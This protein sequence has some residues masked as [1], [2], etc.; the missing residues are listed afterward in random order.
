[1]EEKYGRRGDV[2][3]QAPPKLLVAYLAG[4]I[5]FANSFQV[6]IKLSYKVNVHVTISNLKEALRIKVGSFFFS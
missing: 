5:Y 6:N 1:V 4:I 3:G 2:R